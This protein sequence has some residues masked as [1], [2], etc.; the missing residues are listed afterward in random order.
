MSGCEQL[1][2]H[3]GELVDEM[4]AVLS[5]DDPQVAVL[6]ARIKAPE[7]SEPFHVRCAERECTHGQQYLAGSKCDGKPVASGRCAAL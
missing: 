6:R 5:V 1:K 4:K 2:L 3:L 7:F